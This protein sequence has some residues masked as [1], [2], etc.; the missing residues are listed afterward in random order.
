[1]LKMTWLRNK[2]VKHIVIIIISLAMISTVIL[3]IVFA[4]LNIE[5]TINEGDDDDDD[6]DIF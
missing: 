3:A 6:C 5:F 2:S 1:M 4:I